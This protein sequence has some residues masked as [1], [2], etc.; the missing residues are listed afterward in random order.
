MTEKK[1]SARLSEHVPMIRYLSGSKIFTS[2]ITGC[3]LDKGHKVDMRSTSKTTH[4]QPTLTLFHFV[5]TIAIKAF[6]T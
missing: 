1:V 5:S 3:L 4:R 2:A 6:P